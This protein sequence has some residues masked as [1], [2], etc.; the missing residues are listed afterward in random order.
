M[1]EKG[2]VMMFEHLKDF[3]KIL[4]TG[5]QRS[6]T[7]ICAAMIAHDTGH[8]FVREDEFRNQVSLLMNLVLGDERLS[9]QCPAQA[10]WVA[11][12][13]SYNDVAVVW[14]LRPLEEI[15]ASQQRINWQWEDEEL[16]KYAGFI[17]LDTQEPIASVKLRYWQVFQKPTILHPYEVEYHSL[18]DHPLW[19]DEETR[20][21]GKW[22]AR[23]IDLERAF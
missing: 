1:E 7:T 23:Q 3:S 17:H 6:G 2:V 14:M 16:G 13:G 5:P 10:R 21:N 4:V 19:I 22:G 9:I 8:R 12:F 20:R 11:D 15:I 18:A